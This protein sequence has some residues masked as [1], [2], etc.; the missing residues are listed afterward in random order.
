MKTFKQFIIEYEMVPKEKKFSPSHT[1]R[2]D[3][4]EREFHKIPM[5][6]VDGHR[7]THFK[8]KK[9]GSH[10]TFAEDHEGN[11]VVSIEHKK[12]TVKGRL[13]ISNMTKVGGPK[14]FGGKVLHHL[15]KHGHEIESDNTNSERAHSMWMELGNHP[16]IHTRIEDGNGNNI[17]HEGS[18]SSEE[19]QK[20]FAVKS[21]DDNFLAPDD[22][23]HKN[24]L[25]MKA[26]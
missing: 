5:G 23:T 24:I 25:A 19:N 20:K 3:I 12:P 22:T 10:F 18:I 15:I 4:D 9:G 13:A 16:D 21:T 11:T 1:N 17:H 8:H 2:E 7:V 26:K 6:T 14:K